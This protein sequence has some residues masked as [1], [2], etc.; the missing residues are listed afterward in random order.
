MMYSQLPSELMV[1]TFSF[2]EATDLRNVSHTCQSWRRLATSENLMIQAVSHK[3]L[4]LPVDDTEGSP[5]EHEYFAP[6]FETI[7]INLS[8]GHSG[9]YVGFKDEFYARPKPKFVKTF[10]IVE[11][12]SDTLSCKWIFE[13]GFSKGHYLG[14]WYGHHYILQRGSQNTAHIVGSEK[15]CRVKLHGSIG[16]IAPLSKDRFL[17]VEGDGHFCTYANW[18]L[19][20]YEREMNTCGQGLCL[21]GTV[22]VGRRSTNSVAI[23]KCFIWVI[24]KKRL[25]CFSLNTLKQLDA[26]AYLPENMKPLVNKTNYMD[27]L[28]GYNGLHSV[29]GY[30]LFRLPDNVFVIKNLET[31]KTTVSAKRIE[32]FAID[33]LGNCGYSQKEKDY[34]CLKLASPFNKTLKIKFPGNCIVDE[35]IALRDRFIAVY[36]NSDEEHLHQIVSYKETKYDHRNSGIFS[37]A[38]Q[39]KS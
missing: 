6:G 7:H 8:Y 33:C 14:R 22:E 4:K 13:R 27:L 17:S 15:I 5:K 11:N 18:C 31:G 23:T 16:D 32:H 9:T 34:W 25:H 29:R 10:K 26:N 12:S 37:Q 28:S 39:T 30:C 24:Q 36:K 3:V 38:P 19:H 2:L 35:I 1:F 21:P 20:E